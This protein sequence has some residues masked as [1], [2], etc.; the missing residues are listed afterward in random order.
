[1]KLE[2]PTTDGLPEHLTGSV[3]EEDGKT[4]IDLGG[5]HTA[6]E[7]NGLKTAL[8]TERDAQK[9]YRKLGK[10]DEL[11]QRLEQY[12]ADLAEARKGGKDTE[13][14]QA[15]HDATLN[16]LKERHTQEVAELTG[17]IDT[18]RRN[19][20]NA[21]LK[22]ELAKV[23]VVENGL[24]VLTTMAS[25]R[26]QFE[27]DGALRILKSDGTPDYTATLDGLA[28]E[29]AEGLPELVRD[30]GTPGGGTPPNG[31]TPRTSKTMSR[32]EWRKLPS[33]QRSKFVNDGGKLTD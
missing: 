17:Q 18:M 15:R 28:K 7:I 30:A 27:D 22:A 3:I 25:P 21:Q 8:G 11:K 1:M 23:G 5:L 19:T 2:L 20:V 32:A 12:E 16:Q 24:D 9:T 6:D 14:L 10:P 4:Y 31:G 33:A 29:L 13:A 26:I